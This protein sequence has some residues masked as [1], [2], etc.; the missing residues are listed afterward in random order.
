MQKK[1]MIITG[2]PRKDGNTASLVNWVKDGAEGA[3]AK[4]KI[5]DSA[6]I[7]YNTHGCIACMGCQ[8]LKKY[9]CIIKDGAHEILK[10]IPENDVVVFATPV[11]FMGFTAQIKHIID[12]MF[13]LMKFKPDHSYTHPMKNTEL[14]LIA[15][16]GGGLEDG[17]Y[18]TERTML[19]IAQVY[20]PSKKLLKKLLV[21][22]APMDT[23]E[24]VNNEKIKSEALKFGEKLAK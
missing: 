12:R 21:P 11:Y 7:D 4:V 6:K 22:Y 8:R 1:I 10:E 20:N 18:L 14:A 24:I 19:A 23:H 2:S 13:S 3:G 16:S 17:L 15:S 9:E 5:V